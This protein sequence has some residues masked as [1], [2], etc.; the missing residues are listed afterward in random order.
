LDVWL[1]VDNLSVTNCILGPGLIGR[2]PDGSYL[3]PKDD[4]TKGTMPHACG[5]RVGPG[6]QGVV[7]AGCLFPSNNRR[8]PLIVGGTSA[9]VAWCVIHNP[10]SQPIGVGG[11]GDDPI[12]LSVLGCLSI[13]GKDTPQ[14]IVNG[15]RTV[16]PIVQIEAACPPNSR[17]FLHGNLAKGRGS[18]WDGT[19]WMAGAP[20]VRVETAPND[21]KKA[22]LPPADVLKS[23]LKNVGAFPKLRDKVDA[24]I[25]EGVRTGSGR[26]P[27]SM[28]DLVGK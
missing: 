15:K 2:M 9:V 27:N 1:G 19:G 12:S 28:A 8:S 24:A 26:I 3:H 7:F 22:G 14:R 18:D 17:V 13:P 16:S 11:Y 10:G 25:I 23:V 6:A 4:G 5:A 20:N 21:T